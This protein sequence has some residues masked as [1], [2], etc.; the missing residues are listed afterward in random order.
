MKCKSNNSYY[1]KDRL[2][3]KFRIIADQVQTVTSIYNSKI[4]SIDTTKLNVD[5]V[6]IDIL[7]ESIEQINTILSTVKTGKKLT[8]NEYTNGNL[9]RE[10]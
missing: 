2:G 9:N 7:D 5:S 3:L 8:G 6:R 1:L 10:I 4:M